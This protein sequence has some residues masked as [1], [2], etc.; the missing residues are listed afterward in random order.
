MY[1]I[2]TT[3]NLVVHGPASRES[4]L[5]LDEVELYK[6]LYEKFKFRRLPDPCYSHV[7]SGHLLS[8]YDAVHYSYVW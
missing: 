5:Q 2:S 1:S 7:G 3:F 6:D 4:L 8:G